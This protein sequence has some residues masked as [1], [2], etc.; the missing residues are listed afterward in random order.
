MFQPLLDRPH[1]HR[2]FDYFVIIL[3]KKKKEALTPD[4]TGSEGF[5]QRQ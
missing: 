5:V 1:V 2:V 4:N 3:L